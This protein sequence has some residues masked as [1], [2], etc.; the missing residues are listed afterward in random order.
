MVP[1]GTE[2]IRTPSPSPPISGIMTDEQFN[3]ATGSGVVV[4]ACGKE[5]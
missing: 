2:S 1:D 3:A 5:S 4:D